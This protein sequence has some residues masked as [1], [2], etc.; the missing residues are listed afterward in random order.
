M[1]LLKLKS[2]TVLFA[3]S[4]VLVN[5]DKE[6]KDTQALPP[7]SV[8]KIKAKGVK[9]NPSPQAEIK[10]NP[11]PDAQCKVEN[12]SSIAALTEPRYIE[13]GATVPSSV[14]YNFS[15]ATASD[16]EIFLKDC[17]IRDD[18]VEVYVDGCLVYT[19]DSRGGASGTH[20]GE[21]FTITLPA[22]DHEI[23]Y[24]NTVSNIGNSGW[25]VSETELPASTVKIGDCNTGV[26]NLDATCG[27]SFAK[28]IADAKGGARNH[29]AFVSKVAHLTG[30]WVASGLITDAQKDAIMSCVGSSN[31]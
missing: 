6:Q 17:C 25:Y 8:A 21:S 9:L 14:L 11:G 12:L 26:P 24:R 23:E 1:R 16:L 22:G 13:F 19:V 31:K 18:V 20:E 15:L 29:G 3:L 27:N 28:L 4:L 30:S 7:V 2:L 5:C 10:S